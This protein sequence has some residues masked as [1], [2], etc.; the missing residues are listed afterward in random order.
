MS[1]IKK[2]ARAIVTCMDYR[3]KESVI[4]EEMEWTE[5]YVLRNAGGVV[6]ADVI[7]SLLLLQKFVLKETYDIEIAVV[8][9]TDCGMRV[10]S[11]IGDN[12]MRNKIESDN[13]ICETPPFALESFPTPELGVRRS[14]QR[15]RTS[16]FVSPRD[17][18]W[19]IYGR[20][21]D[22]DRDKLIEV[23]THVVEAGEDWAS[24]ARQYGPGVTEEELKAANP[25]ARATA[26]RAGQVLYVPVPIPVVA[27]VRKSP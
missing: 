7:R 13:W 10:P 8:A 26:L 21:Y 14:I 15:I 9:H 3:V 1:A 23:V 4:L 11:D 25:Q 12:E 19:R 27:P 16:Y 18:P 22:V 6:T 24:V 2:P 20:V 17:S 5:A